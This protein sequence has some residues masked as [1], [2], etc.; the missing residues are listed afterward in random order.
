LSAINKG[1][2]CKKSPYKF[3]TSEGKNKAGKVA[4]SLSRWLVS[5]VHSITLVATGA[6]KRQNPPTHFA[7]YF[8]L[9][10][11]LKM[12]PKRF[13]ILTIVARLSTGTTIF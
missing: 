12:F 10:I 4:L 9:S 3:V 8:S 6:W 13:V 2:F 7:R 1:I 5:Y 11:I